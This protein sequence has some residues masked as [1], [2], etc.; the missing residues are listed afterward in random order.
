MFSAVQ[1][2]LSGLPYFMI[3]SDAPDPRDVFW[4]NVGV[5]RV[6]LENRKILVQFLLLLGVLAWG[7]I[8]TLIHSFTLQVFGTIPFGGFGATLVQGELKRCNNTC[9]T[10]L[11]RS[12]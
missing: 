1:C 5:S 11:R 7:S 8:V 6:T 10:S 12:R 9:L 4:K 2:N 3:T